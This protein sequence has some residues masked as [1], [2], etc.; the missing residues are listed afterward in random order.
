MIRTIRLFLLV[1]AVAFATAA[2]THFGFLI[3]GY[4]HHRAGMAESVIVFALLL[5][6]SAS[7]VRPTL[8]ASTGLVAQAFA[9]LGT[10]VGIFTI[11]IGIGPRT[12]PDVVYHVVIVIVLAT[13]VAVSRRAR[14]GRPGINGE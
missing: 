5:G 8:T 7:F 2:L 10:L 6:L 9:L 11:I 4:A 3:P 14:R 13:G 12:V 1:E